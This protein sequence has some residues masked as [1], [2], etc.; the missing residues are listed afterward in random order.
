[1]RQ[2]QVPEEP[3]RR[4]TQRA[5]L[6]SINTRI[7][8]YEKKVS[9]W[10]D[11]RRKFGPTQLSTEQMNRIDACE[12]DLR[13]ILLEYKNLAVQLR[14]ETS[15]VAFHTLANN[16]LMR[17]NYQDIDY[18]ESGC[19]A[20]LG[21]LSTLAVAKA[22]P[23]ADPR[24][25]DAF[26][27]GDY[28]QVINLAGQSLSATGQPLP[29]ATALQY[30][31]ALVKNHQEVESYRVLMDLVPRLRESSELV[32]ELLVATQ[33][34]ADLDFVQGSVDTA[35][36]GYEEV[37]R[38]SIEQRAGREEWAGLQLAGLQPGA[39]DPTE[40]RDYAV[41]VKNHLAYDPGRD[42]TSVVDQADRFAQTYPGSRLIPNVNLI[43]TESRNQAA[44]WSNRQA[45]PPPAPAP[46]PA[47][48][49]SGTETAPPPAT[50]PP[51]DP[52]SAPVADSSAAPVGVQQ[53]T[54]GLQG[55]Y[56]QGVAL[57]QARQYDQAL[58]QLNP[59]L[60][61]EWDAKARPKV[62]EAS[63]LGAQDA[64]QKAAE[65]FVRAN[66]SG[67][68]EEKRQ[69]LTTARD[70]LQNA[71]DKYPLS[72]LSDRVRRNLSRIETELRALGAVPAGGTH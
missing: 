3:V 54:T 38:L 50:T 27:Q 23:V 64:R 21:E 35:R 17:L 6:S 1:M 71:L 72:G 37:V 69:L 5:A 2:Q 51:A 46:M 45:M 66:S 12:S 41:L 28:R 53:G 63:R 65:Y 22:V 9:E 58:E 42:G 13:N 40:M 19:S 15:E 25:N 4:E 8:A 55:R 16:E 31:Q 49:P 7:Q 43:R 48:A 47:P 70:L 30:A 56:D 44:A 61:T 14:Q 57:L 20:F 10:R 34:V 33:L 26:L 67:S 68:T 62:E 11:V 32:K 52:A 36:R 24:I 60:N 39:I 18:L 29:P 59:L